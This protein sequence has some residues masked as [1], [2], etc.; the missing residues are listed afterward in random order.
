MNSMTRQQR[1]S[2]FVHAL[3]SGRVNVKT[4]GKSSTISSCLK[5]G[6]VV[7]LFKGDRDDVSGYLEYLSRCRDW[8][9]K[10]NNAPVPT[11][12]RKGHPAHYCSSAAPTAFGQRFSL[13]AAMIREQDTDHRI[14]DTCMEMGDGGKMVFALMKMAQHDPFLNIGIKALGDDTFTRWTAVSRTGGESLPLL[15]MCV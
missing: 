1:E 10:P 11:F 5:S 7:R 13:T 12:R 4:F 14:F 3:T 6:L 15:G 2:Q 9:S 8:L